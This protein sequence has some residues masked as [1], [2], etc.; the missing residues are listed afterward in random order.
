MMMIVGKTLSHSMAVPMHSMMYVQDHMNASHNIELMTDLLT[1]WTYSM[2]SLL[3]ATKIYVLEFENID[4]NVQLRNRH[5]SI[6]ETWEM[7]TAYVQITMMNIYMERAMLFLNL[8]VK[9]LIL[10]V[11]NF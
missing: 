8:Y 4:F 3:L 2:K 1:V 10:L 11:A 9:S 7:A 6:S 5:V